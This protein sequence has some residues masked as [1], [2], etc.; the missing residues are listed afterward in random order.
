MDYHGWYDKNKIVLKEIQNS[1][2]M[3]CMNPTAGSFNITPRM[4]QRFVTFAVQMPSKEVIRT[5]F[6]QIIEGHLSSFDPDVSKYGGKITDAL[7]ELHGAVANTFL[8]S[9]VKFHYQWNLRELSNVTQGVCRALPEFYTNP[10]TLCRLWIHEAERVFGDRMV[11]QTDITKFDEMRVA[12]TKKYFADE[13][14]EEI[15][16][17]PISYNAFMKFDSNDEGAFCGARRTKS[18][19]RRWWKSCTSTTSPTR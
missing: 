3:A 19:T 6:S 18:S 13:N 10:V 14:Q 17:R 11:H 5:V 16:A 1:Q 12:V 9:A 7:I 15:E 4:Q 8:P 2:Y